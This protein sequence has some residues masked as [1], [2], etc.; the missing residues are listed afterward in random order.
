M[1]QTAWEL[2]ANRR[3]EVAEECDRQFDEQGLRIQIAGNA[4]YGD[5]R[6]FKHT[7][8]G[9]FD[10]QPED[11]FKFHEAVEKV[12]NASDTTMLAGRRSKLGLDKLRPWDTSVDLLAG[13]A[14]AIS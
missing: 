14:Q 9:R 12:V 4:G 1:R 11:C 6:D 8:K 2:V 3:L 5:Y 7:A 10:Y 13:A